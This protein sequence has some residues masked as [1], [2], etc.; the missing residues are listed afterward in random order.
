MNGTLIR[1]ITLVALVTLI[2]LVK[3]P[4]K[5]FVQL[6]VRLTDLLIS[7]SEMMLIYIYI[8]IHI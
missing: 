8:Y 7:E 6:G 5:G 3:V 4:Y 2:A 1:L